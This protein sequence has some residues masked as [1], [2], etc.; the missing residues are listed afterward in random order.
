LD[1]LPLPGQLPCVL[2]EDLADIHQN[3]RG[4]EANRSEIQHHYSDLFHHLCPLPTPCH[5]PSS[6]DWPQNIPFGDHHLLGIY[7]DCKSLFSHLGCLNSNPESQGFG[8][9]PNWTTLVGLR[10]ILGVLEAGFFPGCAYLLS[11]WYPRYQLHKRN[12][13]FYLIGS[14]ASALSGILAYGLMQMDGIGGLAGWRWIFVVSF[15]PDHVAFV[16][17][18]SEV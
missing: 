9:T 13:V 1:L 2:E 14:M 10:V 15:R 17:D 6:Q 3:G 7:H 8:F 5:R 18:L 11:C 4:F 16:A 12:A